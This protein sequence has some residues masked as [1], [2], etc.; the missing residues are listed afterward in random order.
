MGSEVSAYFT[1]VTS[2]TTC[3]GKFIH[4]ARTDPIRERIFHVKQILNFKGRE[5]KFDVKRFAKLIDKFA[6]PMLCYTREP[7]DV[8]ETVLTSERKTWVNF[9][10]GLASIGLRTTGP[11]KAVPSALVFHLMSLCSWQPLGKL[12]VV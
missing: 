11:R 6:H 4:D 9:Y 2:I 3:T 12:C 1:N 10:R 5:N 7:T 8:R